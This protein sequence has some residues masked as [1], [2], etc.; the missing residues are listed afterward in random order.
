MDFLLPN[1]SVWSMIVLIA[2]FLWMFFLLIT[3]LSLG[4]IRYSKFREEKA[5]V[6]VY[7]QVV[8]FIQ[9]STSALQRGQEKTSL[10]FSHNGVSISNNYQL[11]AVRGL[12]LGY[13]SMF[14]GD[15]RKQIVGIIKA[16]QLQHLATSL[17]NRNSS[18]SGKTISVIDSFSLLN[19]PLPEDVVDKLLHNDNERVVKAV[20]EHLIRVQ[21]IDALPRLFQ[22][23]DGLSDLQVIELY[24]SIRR[25]NDFSTQLFHP[26][27]SVENSDNKNILLLNIITYKL[28][29]PPMDILVALLDKGSD[30]LRLKIVNTIGKLLYREFEE[31]L[32]GIFLRSSKPVKIEILKALG[33]ISS[34]K[35]IDFLTFVFKSEAY[36]PEMRMHAYKSLSSL[37]K[38]YPS[39]IIPSS[40]EMPIESEKIRRFIHEPLIKYI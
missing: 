10:L 31:H 24:E 17:L 29:Y 12:L 7:D 30:K 9:Q 1:A 38:R 3:L 18:V 15:Y 32:A 8:G 34:G 23:M 2:F 35:S 16:N 13:Y 26:Y 19:E 5:Y 11:K 37:E 21:G 14:K 22:T 4:V 6:D 39:L 27:L 28:E 20:R 36:L 25:L 40:H 33:R